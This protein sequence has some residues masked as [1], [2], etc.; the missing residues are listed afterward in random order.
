M[1]IKSFILI[2][3]LILNV[4]LILFS[5]IKTIQCNKKLK[6]EDLTKKEFELKCV[7]LI[8]SGE[9]S[10]ENN[11]KVLKAMQKLHKEIFLDTIPKKKNNHKP[12]PFQGLFLFNNTHNFGKETKT[13]FI[14]KSFNLYLVISSFSSSLYFHLF[15]LSPFIMFLNSIF[16]L[17]N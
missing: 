9:I 17:S 5:I 8:C 3:S 7:E 11:K 14:K 16:S 4:I 15:Q 2:I 10:F 12:R 13:M 6:F 1:E